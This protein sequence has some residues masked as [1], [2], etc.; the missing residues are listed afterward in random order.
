MNHF[1]PF[2]Y[3]MNINVDGKQFNLLAG[4]EVI[5]QA[6]DK[7]QCGWRIYDAAGWRNSND[8]LMA[9]WR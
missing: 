3:A 8:F 7:I 2:H 1:Y 9:K 4:L 6:A 5:G